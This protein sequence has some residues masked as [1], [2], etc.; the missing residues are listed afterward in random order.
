MAGP[1]AGVVD[2]RPRLHGVQRVAQRAGRAIAYRPDD[3]VHPPAARADERLLTEVEHRGEPVGAQPGVLAQA[4]VV[5]HRYLLADIGVA[6]VGDPVRVLNVGE[7]DAVAGAVAGRLDP[8]FAASAQ[9]HQRPGRDGHAEVVVQVRGVHRQVRAVREDLDLLVPSRL[10][11]R[12]LGEPGRRRSLLCQS[13]GEVLQGCRGLSQLRH[14]QVVTAQRGGGPGQLPQISVCLRRQFRGGEL[15]ELGTRRR[16][17]LCGIAAPGCPPAEA[18]RP[19]WRAGARRSAGHGR[20]RRP[21]GQRGLRPPAAVRAACGQRLSS[22]PPGHGMNLATIP[23][24]LTGRPAALAR[25]SRR[26]SA[27]RVHG[28]HVIVLHFLD[29]RE[30][31]PHRREEL[32]EPRA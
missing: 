12:Q 14:F 1:L 13:D 17:R 20:R 25:A 21:A 30:K 23:R 31:R 29:L 18:D 8:G 11:R 6:P 3:F 9:R 24:W 19:R 32:T 10:Q 2:L 15:S 22:G 27:R 4:A 5:Q 7:A 16:I 28:A 26:V